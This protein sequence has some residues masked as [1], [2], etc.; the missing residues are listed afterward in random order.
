V[1]DPL[2]RFGLMTVSAVSFALTGR[3]VWLVLMSISIAATAITT[4]LFTTFGALLGMLL[5]AAPL[6][7]FY[8]AG[9]ARRP[10]PAR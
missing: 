9:R 3:R 8:V 4:I 2:L 7:G 6:Y 1:A 5:L 10:T